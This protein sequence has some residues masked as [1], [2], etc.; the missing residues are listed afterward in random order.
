MAKDLYEAYEAAR[1]VVEN[2][3]VDR[4]ESTKKKKQEEEQKARREGHHF[5]NVAH[6]CEEEVDL[7]RYSVLPA[8]IHDFFSYLVLDKYNM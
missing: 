4:I 1:M 3:Q 6:G 7:L 5:E 8:V 2:A